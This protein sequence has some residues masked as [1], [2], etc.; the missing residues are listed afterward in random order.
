MKSKTE[1]NFIIAIT[2]LKGIMGI[3]LGP[4]LTTYFIKT[5]TE[6]I[7][8]LSLYY[9]FS[10]ILLGV[11]CF[12]VGSIIKSKFKIG[13]FRL[14]VVVNFI[15][16]LTIMLLKENMLKYL[17][18][19]SILYGI[20]ASSYWF[21]YNMFVINK[22]DNSY[23][24][25][26]TVKLKNICSIIGIICPIVL[27]TM[28]TVTN[29]QLT[30]IIMLVCSLIQIILS[31]MLTPMENSN[32]NEFN[33]RKVWNSIKGNKQ[34]MSALKM[35]YFIGMNMSDGALQ[36]LVTI[37]IFNSLKTDMNLGILTS[38]GTVLSIITL[39][40]YGKVYKYKKDDGI[41]IISSIIPIL[42]LPILLIF[43][44]KWLVIFYNL[45]YV[46]FT[47]IINLTRDVRLYNLSSSNII[48][49]QKQ[50]EFLSIREGV[51]NLGRVTSYLL[52]LLA[53][54][55]ES[56]IVLNIVMIFLTFTI[57][58]TGISMIGIKNVENRK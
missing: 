40:L 46:V 41:I 1:G 16:I 29:Y 27:G 55:S 14:G 57:V 6:S 3:F 24:T 53:G 2:A 44:N 4:F 5:S 58:T 23:R 37:L 52:L 43:K 18:L 10:S 15:Y 25:K 11:G 30:A 38:V 56:E 26:Y 42:I 12:I 8:D 9:I 49:Q 47:S 39:Y 28:I 7:T 48:G 36:I 22:I 33:I 13:M 19:V 21:P 51:L 35:E 31:F 54:I 17:W 34:A 32:T 45:C 50:A 20:S